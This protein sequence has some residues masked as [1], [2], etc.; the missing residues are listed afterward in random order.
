MLPWI[1]DDG[2]KRPHFDPETFVRSTDTINLI[3]NEDGGSARAI[4]GALTT[5][6]LMA[7]ERVGARQVG[8][9]L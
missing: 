5:V 3:A 1:I 9:R 2:I 4:T 7:A 6:I 8:G